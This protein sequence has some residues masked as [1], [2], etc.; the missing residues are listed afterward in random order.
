[1]RDSRWTLIAFEVVR[2][3]PSWSVHLCPV[4]T[5]TFPFGLRLW[6]P[7]KHGFATEVEAGT[8]ADLVDAYMES[9]ARG[10]R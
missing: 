4:E 9:I 2:G 8:F 6:A 3:R 7:G 1:M 10:L 5:D